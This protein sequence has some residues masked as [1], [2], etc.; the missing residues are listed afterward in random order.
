MP[1]AVLLALAVPLALGD[2]LP[3]R[4]PLDE[5]LGDCEL[6][7]VCVCEGVDEELSVG[8]TDGVCEVEAETVALA[9]AEPERVPV[10]LGVWVM[11]GLPV[12]V[13][14]CDEL[15]LWLLVSVCDGDGEH[16]FL[17]PVTWM[18]AQDASGAHVAPEVLD[19]SAWYATPVPGVGAVPSP[20]SMMSNHD[21]AGD[22]AQTSTKY[23][24]T[25]VLAEK[26][27][28]RATSTIEGVLKTDARMAAA[29]TGEPKRAPVA[30]E[31]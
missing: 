9:V 15:W 21:T 30:S 31:T 29:A 16:R 8:V 5:T 28:G 26:D 3:L 13:T 11:L 1:L 25:I 17:R 6:L 27:A 12:L 24:E 10:G 7:L 14:V 22:A 23:C 18:P 4:V 19:T 20:V 2:A